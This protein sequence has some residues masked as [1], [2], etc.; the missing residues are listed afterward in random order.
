MTAAT[1][2]PLEV[3]S[4]AGLLW[5]TDQQTGGIGSIN[6]AAANPA[7][8]LQE[9]TQT[10]AGTLPQAITTGSDGNVWFT[11]AAT[12]SIGILSTSN[13]AGPIFQFNF[14]TMQ[15]ALNGA[16]PTS[17]TTGPDGNIWFTDPLYNQ[18]GRITVTPNPAND[19]A[20]A[21]PVPAGLLG[22]NSLQSRIISG[23]G[24]K[25]YFTEATFNVGFTVSSSAIGSYNPATNTWGESAHLSS[26][27]EPLDLTA[28]PNQTL[29]V[30]EAVLTGGGTFSSSAIAVL[31]GSQSAP[32]VLREIPT[33]AGGAV[34]EPIRIT[35]GPDGNI[36]FSDIANGSIDM[37]NVTPV[38]A[39]DT[40]TATP[41]PHT[42]TNPHPA[43][44]GIVNGPDGNIEF[45][46]FKDE[47][48]VATLATQLSVG[49]ESPNPVI[50][51][52]PFGATVSVVYSDTGAVKQ[53][54]A[55][56]VTISLGANPGN[57]T[58]GG[59]LTLPATNGVATFSGLSLNNPGN[60][61]TLRAATAGLPAATGAAFNVNPLLATQFVVTAEP[62][63]PVMTNSTFNVV[64]EAH[65]AANV[66][67]TTY[68]GSVTIS[69][70]NNPGGSTL[71]G[72][73]TVQ[74][75]NGVATF[76]GLTLNGPG[77]G[78]TLQVTAPGLT[79]AV[80]TPFSV[81]APT[82]P[83]AEI[84]GATVVISQKHNKKG[85][86]VG[87]PVL[88]GYQFNFNLPMNGSINNSTNFTLAQYVQVTVRVGKKRK[89]VLQLQPLGF[90]FNVLSN[91]AVRLLLIGKPA[92]KLGGQ[93]TL[94]GTPPGGLSTQDGG[95]L[96]GNGNGI[97]GVN[98]VYNIARG[99]KVISHA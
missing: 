6:P 68:N 2:G 25:L 58:L 64:V 21:F 99:G 74:A 65:T 81:Q 59:T 61:Y 23:P 44:Q 7:S 39:N 36:W 86:P 40:I 31:D 1:P 84:T 47:V 92:F 34:P 56:N 19:V 63:S 43:P 48:G 17:I 53:A 90:S 71:G 60:G 83:P 75:Q 27:E 5:F 18:L 93:I 30:G 13:P 10:L 72:T 85:R 79:P 12:K 3:T 29:W 55:G 9:Y 94:V 46:D 20:T 24:G 89:K 69:L 77:T 96:D 87:R 26:G 37:V 49:P 62:P 88:V 52:N 82:P 33:P 32:P 97:G 42:A 70:A 98:A 38:V 54:F 50:V 80:T 14:S 67:D 78:Y 76:T 45:A 41:I 16:V 51:N 57:S 4:A 8:T 95:F 11:E 28:G 15:G 22:F 73:L 91:T 66:I 35:S